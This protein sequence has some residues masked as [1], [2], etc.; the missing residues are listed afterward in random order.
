MHMDPE[1]LAASPQGARLQLPPLDVVRHTLPNGLEIIVQEDHSAPVVSVQLWVETGSIHEDRHL[2]AGMSHML[3][4]MLFKGTATCSAS[5]F[6]QRVQDAGGYINAYT[7]FDRTV[8]WI[9]IP[10]KGA[11]VALE[12]LTDAALH[13]TLPPEEFV[14]EQEVIR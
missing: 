9:D 5:E 10:A 14:K 13:S 6:A 12:L 3:E 4:H 7:S 2:G 11:E 1:L 8:Y